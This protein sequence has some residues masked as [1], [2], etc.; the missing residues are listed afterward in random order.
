MSQGNNVSLAGIFP[1]VPTPF[2]A[3]GGVDSDRLRSNLECL[4]AEPLSGYLLQG[5]NGEFVLLDANERVDVVRAARAAISAER[6]LI[7]GSGMESTLATMALTNRMAEAG[8]DVALVVTPHYFKGAMTAAAL[9]KHYR[10]V[11]AAAPLPIML[12]N[13][14]VFTGIDLPVETVVNLATHANIIGIKDSSGNVGKLGL[15]VR[16]T[17]DDFQVLTGSG[18]TFLP[19]LAVGAVGGMM[20]LANIAAGPLAELL[21][22]FR[23][24]DVE[25][26]AEIQRRLIAPNKAVTAKFGVAGVKAALDMVGGCGGPVRSPLL[27]LQDSERNE[28]RAILEAGGLL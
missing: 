11:A 8:A 16:E 24:G 23:Q 21:R 6:L 26:A 5:S 13:V 18:S 3:A 28:L 25:R 12:Y 15:M 2:N 14:P 27:P 22:F 7:A 20:A 1:A 9:E 4:N 17:P 19:S 10:H